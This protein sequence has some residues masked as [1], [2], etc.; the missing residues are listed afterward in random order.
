MKYYIVLVLLAVSLNT[1]SQQVTKQGKVYEVKKEKIFLDKAD[2]TEVLKIEEKAAILKEATLITAK[3]KKAEAAKKAQEAKE[4]AE[5][6]VAKEKEAKEKAIKKEQK[7][8]EKA[9]KKVEKEKKSAEKALKNKEKSKKKFVKA[10]RNLKKATEKRDKLKI[11][12]KLSPFDEAKYAEK[13]Q[14][15]KIKLNKAKSKL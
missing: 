3:L 2:V 9:A 6:K 14:K 5:K 10:E 7:K 13:I 15:L 11:A 4:K 12:G 8:K 1:F